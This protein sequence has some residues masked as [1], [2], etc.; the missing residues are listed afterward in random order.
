MIWTWLLVISG[1]ASI[2]S[3]NNDQT[4]TH[5]AATVKNITAQGRRTEKVR[6][7]SI[8]FVW[9]SILGQGFAEFGPVFRVGVL[10]ARSAE[11]YLVERAGRLKVGVEDGADIGP[12]T[13]PAQLD[14]IRSQLALQISA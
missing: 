6:M 7:R 3:L 14:T 4:P 12:I 11:D 9:L 10:D 2:G 8:M 1:T 5:A 13:M